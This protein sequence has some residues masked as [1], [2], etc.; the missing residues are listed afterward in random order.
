MMEFDPNAAE[1]E[2]PTSDTT[3]EAADVEKEEPVDYYV[4]TELDQDPAKMLARNRR[5]LHEVSVNLATVESI[6]RQ[7]GFTA[8][9]PIGGQRHQFVT[10]VRAI[11]ADAPWYITEDNSNLFPPRPQ[12]VWDTLA[13]ALQVVGDRLAE[14]AMF[15]A[16]IRSQWSDKD[17]M[18][19]RITVRSGDEDWQIAFDYAAKKITCQLEGP[20]SSVFAQRKKVVI[21]GGW[22]RGGRIEVPSGVVAPPLAEMIGWA[23]QCVGGRW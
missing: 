3:E 4:C 16:V 10:L 11:G 21:D 6:A 23:V 13:E 5:A 22:V 7:V 9:F 17:G 15:A 1:N 18:N 8:R 12:E 20:V 19:R 2:A 14:R